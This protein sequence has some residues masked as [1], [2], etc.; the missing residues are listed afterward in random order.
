MA[1][2][3]KGV[4]L[5][6]MLGMLT[7]GCSRQIDLA[8]IVGKNVS[9]EIRHSVQPP[10]A[11]LEVFPRG[12]PGIHAGWVGHSTVL[13]SFYGT[14]ILMDPNFSNRIKIA[15][16]VVG[17]PVEPEEIKDLDLILISHAH[18]DHL[19]LPS[20][21]RLPR[22]ALLVVPQGCKALVEEAGF[23]RTVELGWNQVTEAYG[24]R[25][26]AIRPAHWGVRSPWDDED[27]GYNSYIVSKNGE[28]ILF[29][30]DTGY[31]KIFEEKGKGQQLSLAFFPISAYKP[32]WF[33]ANHATPEQALQMFLESGA[34][35]MIPI[36]WGT[37]ILSHEPI[38][39][40]LERLK[41]E[42][43]RL[44]VEDRVVILRQ[45]ESFTIPE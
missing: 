39:E 35:F 21:K 15:R 37:F 4:L 19:D 41:I 5:V 23:P 11:K 22:E 1:S 6:G 45:G 7:A 33:Q 28:G 17:L 38:Q 29:A 26:E 36:H 30:G 14:Q 27:R 25:I 34:R 40:P 16:R 8:K 12:N 32:D 24:L 10:A 9:Y 42:A 31:S 2:F 44:G 13:I 43:K 20:L 3:I 18:Y